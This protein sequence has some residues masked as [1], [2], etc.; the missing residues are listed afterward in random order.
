[1]NLQAEIER[2]NMQ[3]AD[4]SVT[5]APALK[6]GNTKGKFR[7]LLTTSLV[8]SLIMLDSNIVAV[9]L[10][11]IGR[12]L[13]ST[14]TQLEWVVSAYLLSYAALLLAAGAYADLKGRKRTMIIGLTLFALSSAAC[15]V[16]STSFL[17]NLSR[18]VQGVG[19]AMLLTSALA[20]I[21]HTFTGPER[22]RAFAIWGACLGIALTVGPVLGG[23]ITSLFG[24]RWVFLI[25]VPACIILIAAT[26][27]FI[28][29][30][31][32]PD[33]KSLDIPGVVTFTPGLFL[34]V[35]ALIDGNEMGWS[36]RPIL[37]RIGAG[38]AFFVTFTLIEGR[39]RRPMVD[40]SLFRHSTFL[41]G[42]FAMIGYGAT[43]QVMVFYLPLFLQNAYGFGPLAA[44]IAMGPFA[45]PM[46]LTPRFT[47]RLARD[48][49][50]RAILTLGLLITFVGNLLFWLMASTHQPYLPFAFAML[51]A[52]MGAGL[53]NGETVKILGGA[54]PA[55][56]AEMASGI[57][58]TTRFIGI[59]FGVA[60]LGAVLSTVTRH[61]FMVSAS[62]IGLDPTASKLAA[63][64]VIS[65]DLM[66]LLH[67]VP[68]G[69]EQQFR[70]AGLSAYSKGFGEAALL[71]A[72]VAAAMSLL[73]FRFVRFGD[74]APSKETASEGKKP[75]MVV[76][77][78]D[79][80]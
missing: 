15:G 60:G 32:D 7:V 73:T 28:D 71:A 24:W 42:V 80:I 16:A 65:G 63:K 30:S 13:K 62:S 29:E 75:C 66:G 14:F 17:L 5:M 55:E 68:R 45:L 69:L 53:L 10:P 12:S 40:F 77:C 4:S 38:L 44:G 59:L 56:R 54:V 61:E 6:S 47:S 34:M 79:P 74:T 19:G 22:V 27:A 41:G 39:Q 64:R 11:A 49:S 51:V 26:Y 35:W 33:A 72:A 37:L 18:S 8:S 57:S 2:G 50:G 76:D 31:L 20:I 70:A 52:G 78:R 23:L 48:I 46:V 25:N 36:S 58:S 9:A 43:A 21:T 1:M 67:A 3:E